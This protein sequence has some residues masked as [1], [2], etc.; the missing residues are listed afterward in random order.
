MAVGRWRWRRAIVTFAAG[1]FHGPLAHLAAGL[2][3][4]ATRRLVHALAKTPLA[5]A[6]VVGAGRADDAAITGI[7]NGD[8]GI[9]RTHALDGQAV[10]LTVPFGF[11]DAQGRSAI[12]VPALSYAHPRPVRR[13][14]EIL[15]SRR[16]PR[17][18]RVA[19]SRY[20][21]SFLSLLFCLPTEKLLYFFGSLDRFLRSINIH[22]G[23]I[24]HFLAGNSERKTSFLLFYMGKCLKP[25][26]AMV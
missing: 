11:F 19:K 3:A 24:S 1:V 12:S 5:V 25:A 10:I 8:R 7:H 26:S 18:R 6:I 13:A 15:L 21:L 20:P 22:S 16:R 17:S 23:V 9:T 14:P 2:G 4:D